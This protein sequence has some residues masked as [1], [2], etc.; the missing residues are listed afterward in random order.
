[1]LKKYEKEY[2]LEFS[3]EIIVFLH[4]TEEVSEVYPEH[5]CIVHKPG[6]RSEEEIPAKL[7]KGW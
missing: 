6:V 3:D 5:D 2:G 4:L 7:M 1:M